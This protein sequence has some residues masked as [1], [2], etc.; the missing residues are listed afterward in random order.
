M[1]A[2][3]LLIYCFLRGFGSLPVRWIAIQALLASGVGAGNGRRDLRSHDLSRCNFRGGACR[4]FGRLCIRHRGRS[5]LASYPD[6]TRDPPPSLS[7]TASSY[8]A[9]RF[10]SCGARYPGY[11]LWP[12]L[13]GSAGVPIGAGSRRLW[14]TPRCGAHRHWCRLWSCTAIYS[15]VRPQLKSVQPATPAADIGIGFFNGVLGGM[16]GLAG[17]C[18]RHLVAYSA[19]WPKDAQR[20]VFQPVRGGDLRDECGVGSVPAAPLTMSVAKLSRPSASPSCSP[21]PGSG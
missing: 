13:V 6:T 4:Q 21:E 1:T 16:T 8:R 2:A 3:D 20:A 15:L 11:R 19:A 7:G 10:G 18:R 12:I 17:H 14:R 5:G 9:Y